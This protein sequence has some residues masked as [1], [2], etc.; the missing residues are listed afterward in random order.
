MS[1]KGPLRVSNEVVGYIMSP[2]YPA[3]YDTDEDCQVLVTPQEGRRF[4]TA[5]LDLDVEARRTAGCYDRLVVRDVLD[6]G[7]TYN[8]CGTLVDVHTKE[9]TVTRQIQRLVV[10]FLSDG[11]TGG[12]GFVVKF[13]GESASRSVE[14]CMYITQ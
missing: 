1:N 13:K 14:A 2:G 4:D 6:V 3:K 5:L 10:S 7:K 8:Y 12:G 11:A 9:P